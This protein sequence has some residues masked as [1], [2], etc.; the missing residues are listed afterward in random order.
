[1]SWKKKLGYGL[2]VA[3][4][5]VGA[6]WAFGG[7]SAQETITTAGNK[8]GDAVGAAADALGSLGSSGGSPPSQRQKCSVKYPGGHFCDAAG[9]QTPC[10]A[11]SYY[12]VTLAQNA[13]PPAPAACIVCKK[14]SFCE[15]GSSAPINCPTRYYC[16]N[17]G[18]K[19]EC[20][21]G[22]YCPEGT[23]E[24]VAC[25]PGAG[26]YCGPMSSQ[27]GKCP[28]G[29][30]CPDNK[31]KQPCPAGSYCPA[32]AREA[33]KCPVYTKSSPLAKDA[34]ECV[35]E[36]PPGTK[37]LVKMVSVPSSNTFTIAEFSGPLVDFGD[38][39][40]LGFSASPCSPP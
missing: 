13:N 28:D 8:A 23:S 11:G 7:A 2:L 30:S 25:G 34:A 37:L 27:V 36:I 21:A 6:Y 26:V 39:K 40:S 4:L 32:N 24:A 20:P 18:Q 38:T 12:T 3:L 33:I 29:Y 22:S 31:T 35:L 9:N 14:G 10:P 16:P 5:L 15:K 19:L 1:M 17:P